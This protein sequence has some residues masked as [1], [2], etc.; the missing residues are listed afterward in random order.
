MKRDWLPLPPMFYK[1][2][3]SG[4]FYDMISELCL[5]G[6]ICH[7]TNIE[8][9][10]RSLKLRNHLTSCEPAKVTTLFL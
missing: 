4:S 2:L 10:D 5:H 1:I 3:L 6:L 8:C 9:K 7:L